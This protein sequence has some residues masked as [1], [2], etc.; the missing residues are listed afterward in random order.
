MFAQFFEP[1]PKNAKD[2]I[3]FFSLRSFKACE[4]GWIDYFIWSKYYLV[5]YKIADEKALLIVMKNLN[6]EYFAALPY[7]LVEDL[8]YYFEELKRFFN[9]FL[10]LPFKIFL[11]DEEGVEALSLKSNPDY[12]VVE[13]EDFKDYIYDADSLRRLA[14]RALQ[15]K[16]NLVNRFMR[17]Y[18]GRWEYISLSQSDKDEVLEFLDNWF[19]NHL[20]EHEDADRELVFERDGIR[21]VLKAKEQM[22]YKIGGIR[23]DGVLKGITLATYNFLEEMVCI[24]VGKADPTITGLY[25]TMNK[26]F[27]TNEF[28]D[29]KLVNFE[30][31][32]GLAGLR[33]SKLSYNPIMYARKYM[34]VQKYFNGQK[35]DLVDPYEDEVKNYSGAVDENT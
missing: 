31:D 16:R 14:G 35:V 34:V 18:E 15:K 13:E 27:L 25:Q 22:D 2:I 21:T 7:C 26:E 20:D 24:S 10:K 9:D 23:I 19:P 6:N 5:R 1:K 32:M 11:A 33:K 28:P 29:A 12:V 3:P 17:D 4:S 8:P 30:D